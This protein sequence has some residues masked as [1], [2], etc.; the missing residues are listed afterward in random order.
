MWRFSYLVAGVAREEWASGLVGNGRA[1][2]A[3]E[4]N[5][6][7][8]GV[9]LC[10]SE[11]RQYHDLRVTLFERQ[12]ITCKTCLAKINAMRK[13]FGISDWREE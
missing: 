13:E 1:I 10:G 4:T 12:H 9:T 6:S 7:R 5:V 2:H 11:R 8:Q 3:V